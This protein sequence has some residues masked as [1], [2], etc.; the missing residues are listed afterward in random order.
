MSRTCET[1]LVGN[2]LD[3]GDAR[4]ARLAR[5]D[6]VLQVTE[7]LPEHNRYFA[8]MST[9]RQLLDG[10]GGAPLLKSRPWWQ[11]SPP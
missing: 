4:V 1:H 8:A 10:I 3:D 6:A 2:D 7:P 9:D 11:N 5:V